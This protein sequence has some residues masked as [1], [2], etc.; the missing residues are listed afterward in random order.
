MLLK[1]IL[2]CCV[3][4]LLSFHAASAAPKESFAVLDSLAGKAEIQKSGQQQWLQAACGAKLYSNDIIRVSDKSL[5]RLS[6]P[7]GSNSFVRAN[8]QIL[9][10]FF[11][12][13]ET[14]LLSTHITVLYGAVFFVIKEI[15]PRAITK[16]YDTKV[17]T[18]T[19]VISVR[20][21]G[22]SVDVDR[23]NGGTLCK[24]VNG[25]I[26]VKNSKKNVSSFINAGFQTYLEA[27]TDTI[28]SKVLLDKELNE[29]KTWVPP[30]ILEREIS[31]QITKAKRDHQVLTN[32]FKDKF[33]IIPFANHSKYKGQWDIATSFVFEMS[34]LLKQMN[35]NVSIAKMD[36]ASKDPAT[37]GRENNAH[38]VILGDI[39]DFDVVQHAEI[40]AAA[41][42]YKEFYIAKVR[43][44]VQL[45]NVSNKKTEFDKTFIGETRGKNQKEN[46]FQK[47]GKLTFNMKDPK[48]SKTILGSSIQQA[49]DQAVEQVVQCANFE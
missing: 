13:S 3:L 23:K 32:D 1:F 34:E 15:L 25:T 28:V 33:I 45:I 49:L 39:E 17:Y 9:L 22:F 44:R 30:E 5:A 4:L 29:L 40:T 31:L 8:S 47:I 38:F 26:L 10:T 2:Q 21:T 46:S 6:W 19:A 35:K 42:E 37:V 43:L 18:P 16:K 7:D 48:F 36:S 27:V 14:N 24:V 11:E 20:G 12:S 41:D